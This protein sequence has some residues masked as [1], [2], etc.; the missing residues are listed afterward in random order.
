[1]L[2]AIES[3]AFYLLVV[4]ARYRAAG[5][6]YHTNAPATPTPAHKPNGPIHVLCHIMH[7]VLSCAAEAQL[8]AL[9]VM[10]RKR[11]HCLVL[12]SLKKWASHPQPA[13]PMV[14]DNKTAIATDTVKQKRSKAIDMRFYL[15]RDRVRQG[16][17]KIYTRSKGQTNRADDNVSKHHPASQSP[18]HSLFRVL[19]FAYASY[20]K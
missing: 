7:K 13:T 8:G 4:K 5:Y 9:S 6:F 1:M 2:L 16:Q 14:T 15:I 12:H 19:I 11:A 17:F 18:G 3:D 10:E 20:A